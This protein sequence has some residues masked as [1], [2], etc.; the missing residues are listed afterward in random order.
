MNTVEVAFTESI[1]GEIITLFPEEPKLQ[2]MLQEAVD[3]CLRAHDIG[4]AEISIAVVGDDQIHEI[5][6]QYLDHDYETDVITFDFGKHPE[7]DALMGEI[8]VSAETA[9]RMASEVNTPP[10]TELIL[11]A[12]HGSLH[13]AGFDDHEEGDRQAMRAAE[14]QMMNQLGYPYTFEEALDQ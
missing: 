14:K 3:Q 11:Y 13:L 12:V 8:V 7:T 2:S 6:R 4:E 10:A 9:A 5:N 1:P